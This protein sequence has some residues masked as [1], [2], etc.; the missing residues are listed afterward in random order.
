MY[1]YVMYKNCALNNL[2][3]QYFKCF[4]FDFYFYANINLF[5]FLFGTRNSNISKKIPSQ[6]LT[7]T[8][9]ENTV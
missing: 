3:L 1:Y 9:V 7:Y 8:L 6:T 4:Y 5:L 2:N